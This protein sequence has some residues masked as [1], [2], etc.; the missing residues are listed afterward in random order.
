MKKQLLTLLFIVTT[1]I[2]SINSYAADSSA[3]G[4][5][6]QVNYNKLDIKINGM[7]YKLSTTVKVHGLKGNK[8][9]DV[10]KLESKMDVD[11]KYKTKRGI[12]TITEIWVRLV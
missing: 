6:D 7:P 1:T 5:I 3:S 2:F 4:Q 9:L 11:F 8:F 12:K 10:K